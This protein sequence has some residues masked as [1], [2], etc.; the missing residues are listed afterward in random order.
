MPGTSNILVF[1]VLFMTYNLRAGSLGSVGGEHLEGAEQVELAGPLLE[2]THAGQAAGRGQQRLL[3]ATRVDHAAPVGG[4]SKSVGR[5]NYFFL[6]G[7][8][9]GDLDKAHK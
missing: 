6:R 5:I 8:G 1:H 7:G 2:H 4:H 3:H 9:D